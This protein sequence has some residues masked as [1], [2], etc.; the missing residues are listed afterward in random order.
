MFYTKTRESKIKNF[1]MSLY[2]FYTSFEHNLPE[3]ISVHVV[4]NNL[5][6][7]FKCG[8][9]VHKLFQNVVKINYE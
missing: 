1:K 3:R 7:T 2:F 9:D 4:N 5:Q 6:Q 8:R